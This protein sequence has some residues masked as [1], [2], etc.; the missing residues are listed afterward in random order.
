LCKPSYTMG[1]R[2][3]V[4]PLSEDVASNGFCVNRPFRPCRHN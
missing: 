4:L 1:I 3:G 2:V